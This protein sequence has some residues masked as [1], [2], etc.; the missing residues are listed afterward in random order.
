MSEVT[1]ALESP[2]QPE[3]A[4]LLAALD[5]YQSALYPAESNHF[6][7]VD[8]LT[9]PAVRFFV[10]RRDGVAIGCAALRIDPDGYGELKRMYVAAEA[11]G[12]K[13]GRRLLG[14]VEE[15]A[16][17][18]GLEC[19]RLETGIHQP[20]A[21]GLYRSAGYREREPFA[22]YAPDPLSVFMEKRL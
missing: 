1:L 13:L 12:L 5:A 4:R 10:A 3:V 17:E 22:D 8:A 7:D 19:V 11:R 14:R 9:G 18:E 20:E 21:L 2:R 15:E 6:L 16:R